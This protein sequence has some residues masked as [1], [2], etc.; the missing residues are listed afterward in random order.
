MANRRVGGI[1]FVKVNGELYN[2][3]GDFSYN[4]GALRREPVV[5]MDSVH[6][7]K[8]SP[9]IPFIEGTFTDSDEL[10]LETLLNVR[11]ATVTL[12]LANGKTVVL[13]EAWFASEG[14]VS[15]GEGEIEVRFEGIRA[16]EFS[17]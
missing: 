1:I 11:D 3:K 8:E 13:S 16:E 15:T 5:G 9:Q 10:D 17:A 2:A 4:L 7:F 6:G 12:N 14:A